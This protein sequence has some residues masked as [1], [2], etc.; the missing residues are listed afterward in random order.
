MNSPE[1]DVSSRYGA[2]MGRP[3]RDGGF[4]VLPNARPFSLRV[5]RLDSGGYDQ[6]GAYW[7]ARPR[8]TQLYYFE[9]PVSDING[10]VDGKSRE[11][12]K[13]KV[14]ELHPNARFYR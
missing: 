4:Q 9:G 10:Y 13:S 2:P 5:V 11:D 12:A 14:R 1:T 7:G 3:T 6:G 8:G